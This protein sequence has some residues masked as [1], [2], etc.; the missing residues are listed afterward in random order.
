MGIELAASFTVVKVVDAS[1]MG[2]VWE[3]CKERFVN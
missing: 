1:V 3:L 2:F